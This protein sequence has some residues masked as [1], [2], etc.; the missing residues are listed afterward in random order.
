MRERIDEID[1]ELDHLAS[2]VET[3]RAE[4]QTRAT[5]LVAGSPELA[6]LAV[7]ESKVTSARLTAVALRDERRR[8]ERT[9]EEGVPDP[10]PHAHLRHRRLPLAPAER[11]RSGLLALWSVVST[12]LILL[13]L[14]SLFWPADISRPAIAIVAIVVLLSIEAF[15]RGYYLAF[16]ARLLFV[17]LF[18]R[19]MFAYWANWQWATTILLAALAVV[20]LIV[21]IRDVR[22][23]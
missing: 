16:L 6:V 19:L 14:A 13:L 22:R 23:R 9:L 7:E 20:V 15:A 10:G 12:P 18:F 5:A 4:M 3:S 17:W 8:L 21:N 1:V 11:G 2:A